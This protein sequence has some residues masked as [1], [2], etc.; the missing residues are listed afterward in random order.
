MSSL[1]D[2]RAKLGSIGWLSI[3]PET[4]RTAV[5]ARV[6]LVHFKAGEPVYAVGDPPGGIY[7]L[8]SGGLGI[9][10]APGERGPYFAHLARPGAWFGEAA[11]IT[12]QGRRVGLS[13]TRDTELLQ[14]PLHDILE[15]SRTDPIIWRF[16]ALITIGHLDLA[17]GASD[18]LMIRDHA[19]RCVAVLLRLGGVRT[20]DPERQDPVDVDVSQEDFATLANVSRT[21]ARAMLG[22]L[23]AAGFIR[24]SYR[25]IT[26]LRPERLRHMLQDT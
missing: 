7:G 2:A 26:V 11:A 24:Q 18:D 20:D 21:T 14:L 6:H 17:I 9:A 10:I 1:A 22:R 4:F 3:V 8:V 12:G 25:R 23:E 5:L 16:M 13:A 19:T 15:M